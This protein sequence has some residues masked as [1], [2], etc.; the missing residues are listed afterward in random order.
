MLVKLCIVK[1]DVLIFDDICFLGDDIAWFRFDNKGVF[2]VINF[3]N[4]F[5]GVVLGINMKINFNVML[6]F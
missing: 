3:E 2:R 6:L 5:F 4:G 1:V